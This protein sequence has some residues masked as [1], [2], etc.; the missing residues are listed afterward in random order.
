MSRRDHYYIGEDGQVRYR[1]LYGMGVDLD[2][3]RELTGP[4]IAG[5]DNNDYT[6]AV[7]RIPDETQRREADELLSRLTPYIGPKQTRSPR[8]HKTPAAAC[9]PPEPPRKP[10]RTTAQTS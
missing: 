6:P 9:T 2:R 4:Y 1:N 10:L 5:E 8:P 3:L 7:A